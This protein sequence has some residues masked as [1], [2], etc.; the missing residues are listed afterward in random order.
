MNCSTIP[1]SDAAVLQ[2]NSLEI[3][4]KK[5]R[6]LAFHRSNGTEEKSSISEILPSSA[7]SLFLSAICPSLFFLTQTG[8]V[9]AQNER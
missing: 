5:N 7:V 6:S 4:E 9:N 8:D 3:L 1:T 2:I